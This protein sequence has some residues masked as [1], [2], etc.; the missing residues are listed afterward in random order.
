MHFGRVDLGRYETGLPCRAEAE[1]RCGRGLKA[2]GKA[3]RLPEV[4][5]VVSRAFSPG[6]SR[7]LHLLEAAVRHFIVP[8]V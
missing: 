8:T 3:R 4:L 5:S 2:P 7:P 1:A 6:A